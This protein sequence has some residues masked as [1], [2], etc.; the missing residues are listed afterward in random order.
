MTNS[1]IHP[2]V[3]QLHAH[4][5]LP[6]VGHLPQSYPILVRDGALSRLK[7]MPWFSQFFF[8]SNKSLQIQPQNIPFCGVYFL[9]ETDTP[10][11]DA[12]VGEPRFRSLVVLG[13]SVIV[14][15]ND[16]ALAEYN[17]DL[18][19]QAI[20]RGL[21]CDHSFYDNKEY[22][23]QAFVR[24]LRQHVFGSAGKENEM[25]IAELRFELTCDLGTIMYEPLV[26]DMLETVHMNAKPFAD[27]NNI[28]VKDI[29]AQFDLDI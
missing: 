26:P 1:N 10:D 25:P 4:A 29:E 20:T 8:T 18:S 16:P 15:N 7:V 28:A 19:Y 12:N 24:G 27:A 11:G 14:Q 9:T 6:Q 22:K 23:I 3:R 17:L 5:K 21:L 2:L 13:F